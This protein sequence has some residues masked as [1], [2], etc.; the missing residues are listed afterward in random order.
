MKRNNLT[1]ALLAGL[2]G[3]AGLASTASA[4]N[5]NAD[6]LGQVLVYPYYSVNSGNQSLVSVVNTTNR[7]KAVKVRF[8]EGRNSKE[9]LDF[10][11]YLSPFDVWTAAVFSL[12]NTGPAHLVTFDTSCT[13]PIL[14]NEPSAITL[15]SGAKAIP[16]K[17]FEYT[18]SRKDHPST[19]NAT[20][21]ALSRTREGHLEMIEMGRLIAGPG[22]AQLADE[23][24]HASTGVP[25]NCQRLENAWIAGG[26]WTTSPLFGNNNIELPSGGLFGAGEIVDVANGTNLSYNA[27]AIEAFYTDPTVGAAGSLHAAPGTVDPSLTDANTDGTIASTFI[28]NQAGSAVTVSQEDFAVGLPTPDAVSLVFMHDSIM[29]EYNTEASLA[30]QSEWVVT[31]PTKRYYVDDTT[32]PFTAILPFTDPFRNDGFA[33]DPISISYWDREEQVPGTP[34]GSVIV[35]PP[36]DA[37][38]PNE[39]ALCH[40]ANIITFNDA[41]VGAGGESPILGARYGFNLDVVR[42]NTGATFK[43]GWMRVTFDDP[44]VAG[45]QNFLPAPSGTEYVGLPVVGFWAANYV[46]SAASAGLLANFSATHRHRGSRATQATTAP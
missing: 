13:V 33:C 25:V 3:A 6:G 37:G 27:E 16:F 24:T 20:H 30:A 41:A 23:A 1:T 5:L 14:K 8:L 4:V 40:E 35:S 29:N 9:V 26:V 32:S 38:D 15:A 46:N 22:D 19:V 28:F 44:L 21:S 11:L 12:D 17:N 39:V 31:F 10:N 2:A 36:P 7:V 45:N 18:G 34:P 43:S 42:D